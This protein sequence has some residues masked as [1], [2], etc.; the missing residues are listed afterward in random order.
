MAIE[1]SPHYAAAQGRCHY[2]RHPIPR[3]HASFDH[4]VPL[5]KGGLNVTANRVIACRPCNRY[6]SDRTLDE[7]LAT[8]WLAARRSVPPRRW[9][10]RGHYPRP[11][12]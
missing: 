11:R 3:G 2:C 4:V 7:F 9:R 1:D 8:P 10:N 5:V 6:K 12:K